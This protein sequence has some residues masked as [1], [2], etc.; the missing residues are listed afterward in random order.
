MLLKEQR[1][2][3]VAPERHPDADFPRCGQTP[4]SGPDTLNTRRQPIPSAT[5]I[6][7]L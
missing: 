4:P 1:E 2:S 5:V 3:A 7:L 6:D